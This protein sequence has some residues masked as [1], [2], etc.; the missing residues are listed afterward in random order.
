MCSHTPLPLL[1]TV[2]T[3]CHVAVPDCTQFLEGWAGVLIINHTEVNAKDLVEL[4]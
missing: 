2:I 1:C 3:F 4:N